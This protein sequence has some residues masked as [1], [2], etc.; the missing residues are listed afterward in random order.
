MRREVKVKGQKN[1]EEGVKGEK[2]EERREEKR[3]LAH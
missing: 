2:R 3:R 1:S